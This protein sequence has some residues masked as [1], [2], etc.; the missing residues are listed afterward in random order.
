MIDQGLAAKR[1]FAATYVME[2]SKFTL[3]GAME[4]S[5]DF[6]YD[7]AKQFE[8]AASRNDYAAIGEREFVPVS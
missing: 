1:D 5:R 2:G 4:R 7:R 8:E 3:V 6:E